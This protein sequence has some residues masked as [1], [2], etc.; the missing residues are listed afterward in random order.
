VALSREQ[1]PVLVARD[2]SG[3]TADC[4]L[5][6]ARKAAVMA[7]LKPLLPADAVV[8]SGGGGSIGQAATDLGPEHHTVLTSSGR[9]AVGAW[10]IQNVNS[11]HAQLKTW[12]RRFHGVATY[13]LENYLGWFRALD[14]TPRNP[15]QPAQLLS[16]AL[17]R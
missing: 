8:C 4:V 16:L 5:A 9:H 17:G 3:L 1:I 10:H 7:L 12:M 14:R 13:Y 2:R 15:A 6:D 11:Y